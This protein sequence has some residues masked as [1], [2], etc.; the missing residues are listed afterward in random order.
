M[1]SSTFSCE[2][3]PVTFLTKKW[4]IDYCGPGKSSYKTFFV[5]QLRLTVRGL[6]KMETDIRM[7]KSQPI[8]RPIEIA[9]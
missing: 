2:T 7:D 3:L 6:K 9:A 8:I 1:Q 4:Q 5:L